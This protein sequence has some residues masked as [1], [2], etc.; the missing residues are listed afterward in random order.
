MATHWHIATPK[1]VFARIR[2]SSAIDEH[3]CMQEPK[4]RLQTLYYVKCNERVV[5]T[6]CIII[7]YQAE[8]AAEWRFCGKLNLIGGKT[9]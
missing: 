7:F 2:F 4:V 3:M 1:I 6:L 9:K 5:F 8:C